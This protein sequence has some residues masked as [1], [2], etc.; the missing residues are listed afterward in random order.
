MSVRQVCKRYEALL[1]WYP[2]PLRR[3]V[4]TTSNTLTLADVFKAGFDDHLKKHDIVPIHHFKIARAIMNC[5]TEKLG[6]LVYRCE[7]SSH[8][9]VLFHSCRNRHCPQCQAMARAAWVTDRENELPATDYF[10]VVFTIPYYF[11]SC[12]H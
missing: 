4:M 6:G 1:I 7:D 3:C 8:S 12:F 11:Y 5:R 2:L 9:Q 10:H